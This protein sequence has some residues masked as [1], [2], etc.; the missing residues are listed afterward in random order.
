[1]AFAELV[2]VS[3]SP[4]AQRFFRALKSTTVYTA[5]ALMTLWSTLA[6][7]FDLPFAH[8]RI[9]AACVYLLLTFA[10]LYFARQKMAALLGLPALF[11]ARFIVVAH[12]EALQQ[13]P[14]ANR[15][16]QTRVHRYRQQPRHHPQL[17]PM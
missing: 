3:A 12:P 2:P 14:L 4:H 7:F 17:S 8:A 10:I 6:L 16:L 15:R 11:R 1:M 13:S 5:I 9:L